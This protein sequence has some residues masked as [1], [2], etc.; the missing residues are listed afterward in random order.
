MYGSA[1]ISSKAFNR[2]FL[3]VVAALAALTFYTTS[4]QT[5]PPKCSCSPTSFTFRLNF[6]GTCESTDLTGVDDDL[7]FIN[8]RPPE[9]DILFEVTANKNDFWSRL[10][11]EDDTNNSELLIL[12]D[13]VPTKVTRV[14]I[15]EY[16][17]SAGLAVI[18]QE[19]WNNQDLSDGDTIQFTSISSNLD[20]NKPL[21]EQLE[22]FP[23]GVILQATGVNSNDQDVTNTFTWEYDIEDCTTEQITTGN[24]IGWMNVADV[25]PANGA[26]C[27][28]TATPS[29][30]KEP[31]SSP[32]AVTS[33]PTTSPTAKASKSKSPKAPKTSKTSNVSS[34]QTREM[35]S[36]GSPSLSSFSPLIIVGICGTLAVISFTCVDLM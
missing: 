22:F 11:F 7:C 18:N 27:P 20:P 3:R 30:T 12:S 36:G 25:T 13:Q 29:P 5:P 17:T 9:L 33:P 23:S 14:E 34:F 26:F 6:Q 2:L 10:S 4:A 21:D 19:I 31:T 15:F 28:A 32:V 35:R 8:V 24:Y 16:D 1:S